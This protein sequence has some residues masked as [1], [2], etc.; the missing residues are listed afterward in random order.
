MR[1][2]I[3]KKSASRL[4]IAAIVAIAAMLITISFKNAEEQNSVTENALS[5]EIEM[6]LVQGN[7]TI[8]DFNIGKYEVTQGQWRAI[9]GN[10]PSENQGGDN[11]PVENV[12]WNDARNFIAQLN[13]LTGKNYRMPTQAEWEYAARG[14]N[15]SQGFTYSGSNNV[16]DVAWFNDNSGRSTHPV[17]TKQPNELGIHDMSGNVWEWCADASTGSLRSIRGGGWETPALGCDPKELNF[18]TMLER[19]PA[20]GFRLAHNP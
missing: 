18:N 17:G 14:G 1:T 8:G 19:N 6:V 15:R 5:V 20:I 10:N 16:N 7:G 4:C 9:M 11:F 2:T 3:F 12:N 13:L